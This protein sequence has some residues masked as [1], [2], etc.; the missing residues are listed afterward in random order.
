MAVHRQSG[1]GP[2]DAAAGFD[3]TPAQIVLMLAGA[4]GA[5]FM[6]A[7]PAVQAPGFAFALLMLP[8]LIK[9]D[10]PYLNGAPRWSLRL[11]Q[12]GCLG[13][14]ALFLPCAL[15]QWVPYSLAVICAVSL[16]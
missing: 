3:G 12:L 2:V 10:A 9:G 6:L 8:L 4:V 16:C 1:I 11:L 15:L 7:M 13:S 5:F 14:L